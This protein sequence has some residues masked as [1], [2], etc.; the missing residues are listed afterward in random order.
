MAAVLLP[1]RLWFPVLRHRDV[2]GVSA[3][4]CS[5]KRPQFGGIAGTGQNASRADTD[6]GVR[7]PRLRLAA[8]RARPCRPAGWRSERRIEHFDAQGVT[9]RWRDYANR[10]V[11]KHQTL[12]VATFVR[13]FCQHLLPRSF[14]K[15]RHYGFLANP[16]RKR[17][18]PRARAAIA[19]RRCHVL[20]YNPPPPT[21]RP[22]RTFFPPVTRPFPTRFR[23]D[24]ANPRPI[25]PGNFRSGSVIPLPPRR[26]LP[27]LSLSRPP[28]VM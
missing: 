20:R 12:P 27:G 5:N 3:A 25:R 28:T 13:H 23:R 7:D 14:A 18:I 19:R 15:I 9:F 2:H 22:A 6:T 17:E 10:S 24:S 1:D 21:A 11:I 8:P 16:A 26:G 4:N